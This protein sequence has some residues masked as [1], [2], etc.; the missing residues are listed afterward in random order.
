MSLEPPLFVSAGGSE[1]GDP[2]KPVA[3]GIVVRRPL[4]S[5]TDS[6]PPRHFPQG[7]KMI[8]E[9]RILLAVPTLDKLDREDFSLGVANVVGGLSCR[10]CIHVLPFRYGRLARFFL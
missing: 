7:I 10:D 8:G 4:D 1:L 3:R 2:D 9:T 6:G 5:R